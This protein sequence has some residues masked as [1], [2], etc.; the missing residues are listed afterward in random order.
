MADVLRVSTGHLKEVVDLTERIQSLIRQVKLQ[1]GLCALF[2]THTTAALATGEIGEGTDQDFLD[3]VEQII[4]S[5]RFRH[6]HDP[7]HA[8]SHMAASLLGP[9]LTLPVRDGR[10]VL[11]TWQSVMLI[12][13][14]G[15]RERTVYVTLVPSSA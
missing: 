6:A 8:W 3:V 1:Q 4:P 9:S 5:I 7:S 2:V 13:L 10:L 11:G 14:D 15:P 12:E